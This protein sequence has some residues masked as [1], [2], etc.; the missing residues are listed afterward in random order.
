MTEISVP[1]ELPVV[2]ESLT[3]DPLVAHPTIKQ[4]TLAVQRQQVAV[5]ASDA[6][7]IPDVTV[8]AGVKRGGSDPENNTCKWAFPFLCHSLTVVREA[9]PLVPSWA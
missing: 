6:Q 2:E 1:L 3:V 4:M 5:R 9:A 8:S 7:R